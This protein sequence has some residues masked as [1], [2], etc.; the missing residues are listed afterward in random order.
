MSTLWGAETPTVELLELAQQAGRLG[1]FEW[2][3]RQGV[4]SLSPQLLALLGL[5]AFD[6]RYESWFDCIFREDKLRVTRLIESAFSERAPD[7]QAEFRY[8]VD[9][10][11]PH[12]MEARY[13]IFYDADGR[14]ERVVGVTADI[15]ERK[16][17]L[18][19]SQ[20]V[21][22]ILEEAVRDRTR[23][24]EEEH[25]AR[26]KA[27]E[28]L[29]QAQRME[30][31]GQLT[32]GIAHDFNNML[33]IVVGSLD[34]ARRRLDRGRGGLERYLDAARDGATRAASLT[35]RLLAF[36][37][38]QP[39]MPRV[40][41]LNR[42]V[43]DISELLRRTLGERI[44]LE[45]VLAG[46]LWSVQV[47]PGQLENA[48]LNLAV[49]ARDAM[50]EG[51]Q[52]TLETANTYLDERYARD[53][54]GVGEG[55][56]VMVAVSDRGCGMSPAVLEK[57]FDPFFTTKPVG[58]GTGLGLS[59]VYGFVKQ[60]RGHVALYSEPGEGTTVKIYLPRHLGAPEELIDG[61]RQ[62]HLEADGGE[63]V[64]V[65]EDDERV[66]QMSVE[67]LKEL[68][69]IVYQAASGEEAL[70]IVD[71]LA[72]LDLLFTDIVMAG[73]SGRQVADAVL[74][75]APDV[76]V[77]YT[78][79]YTRNAVV[80]NGVVDAGVEFLPKPF[81]IADLAAKVRRILDT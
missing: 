32:A 35:Q 27:E 7:L 22:E 68:G 15:T 23:Q 81:S 16:A 17:A 45:T 56:Y 10:G 62:G 8:C 42:L 50:P 64:L 19:Q 4:V 69:Y 57:A 71:T 52:L 2:R 41:N 13:L 47:D 77:L 65:L 33:A 6:G 18:A 38:Q 48:I 9:E 36:S 76:K 31:V 1:V 3:V 44:D 54:F 39:L 80:H 70:R 75:K 72:R 37:R 60:S 14:A 74:A 20:V 5:T 46:G 59:M 55:Q 34:L 58:A 24:L 51:G 12:W 66:R 25:E 28:F 29:R 61:G 26:R 79:G 30:A 63:V 40:L 73:I 78:T 43:G 21:R 53:H 49:N 67:A 11:A